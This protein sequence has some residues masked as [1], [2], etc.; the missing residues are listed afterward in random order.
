[1]IRAR[2]G[3]WKFSVAGNITKTDDYSAAL[4]A[5]TPATIN[6]N[7]ILDERSREYYGEGYRWHDLARTQKWE[8]YAGSYQICTTAGDAAPITV[9]R[10]IEK[11]LYLRPIP[12]SQLDNMDGD[13]AYKKAF[14]NPGYN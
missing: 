6:I 10:T 3:K 5:A 8:E 4:V 13:E 9:N 12:T 7:Y 1:M 2:A 14:Q 11:Y